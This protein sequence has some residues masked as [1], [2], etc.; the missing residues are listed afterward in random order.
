LEAYQT[1]KKDFAESQEA[2]DID[3]YIA[4]ATALKEGN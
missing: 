3:K 4:R 2:Q 1:I